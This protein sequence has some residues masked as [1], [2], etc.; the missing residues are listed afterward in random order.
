MFEIRHFTS[1]KVYNKFPKNSNK[2]QLESDECFVSFVGCDFEQN[3]N[4]KSSIDFVENKDFNQI[5]FVHCDF[6][7]KLEK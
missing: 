3:K 5:E 4:S 6:K 7:G 2:K 1:T